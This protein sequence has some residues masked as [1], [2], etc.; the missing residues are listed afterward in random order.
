MNM[1]PTFETELTQKIKSTHPHNVLFLVDFD[2]S[3]DAANARNLSDEQKQILWDLHR[4]TNGGFIIATNND[5]RGV[6]EMPGMHGFPVISEYATVCRNIANNPTGKTIQT[7]SN[8]NTV[9]Y[10]HPR[11]PQ[12]VKDAFNAAASKAAELNI[13]TSQNP[14]ALHGPIPTL[15]LGEK[16]MGIDITFGSHEPLRDKAIEIAEH[17]FDTAG[18]SRDHY[19]IDKDGK[20]AIEIKVKDAFKANV[21]DL[22]ADHHLTQ[23]RVKVAMGDSGTDLELMKRLGMGVIVGDALDNKD[24]S[25][26]SYIK[27]HAEKDNFNA[28]WAFLKEMR[29]NF[30]QTTGMYAITTRSRRCCHK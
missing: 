30:K 5:G 7:D 9:E 26:I 29:D 18:F 10:L 1:H 2:D 6:V 8:G 15:K 24:K 4:L 20:D 19:E 28:T 3:L 16:E 22:L 21:I 14:D 13:E 17:A 25:G 23:R 11:N 12:Q 27:L